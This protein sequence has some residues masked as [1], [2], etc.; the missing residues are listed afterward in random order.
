MASFP[1][2]GSLSKPG[3]ATLFL[4]VYF[5][6]PLHDLGFDVFPLPLKKYEYSPT[7]YIDARTYAFIY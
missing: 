7:R 4:F 3:P 6:V 2:Y 5:A 1:I